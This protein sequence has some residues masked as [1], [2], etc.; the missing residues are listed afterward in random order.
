MTTAKKCLTVLAS[1]IYVALVSTV[2]QAHETK[3]V[4]GL[5]VLFGAE[6]WSGSTLTEEM[7]WLRW[8]F[9]SKDTDEPFDDIEEAVAVIKKD[10]KEFGPF[11]PRA[12][13]NDPG[14]IQS[15]HIFTVAGDYDAVLTFKKKG[16]PEPYTITFTYRV[17]DRRDLQFPD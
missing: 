9:R 8:R 13:R 6:S 11:E 2:S 15:R 3:E 12:A 17:N 10:G 5:V 16:D 14:L 7:E 4:A 1:L